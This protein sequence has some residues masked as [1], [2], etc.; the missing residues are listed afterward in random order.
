MLDSH[1]DSPPL[2]TERFGEVP[3]IDAVVTHD[4]DRLESSVFVI[5]RSTTDM[6][7]LRLEVAAMAGY[8][9][10]QHHVISDPDLSATN[11]ERDPN[12]VEATP[13]TSRREGRTINVDLPPVSW[14]HLQLRKV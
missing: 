10:A 6:G 13:G 2:Q 12:R 14:S 7:Q 3:I 1:V 4:S 8:E 5:N 9:V 11:T